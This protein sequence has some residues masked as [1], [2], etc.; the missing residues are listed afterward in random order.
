MSLNEKRVLQHIRN[1]ERAL[2]AYTYREP[3]ARFLTQYYKQNRQ[4]GS[5][6]RKM[7]S[8]LCYNY[9][10]IGDWMKEAPLLER[11]TYAEYLCEHDS[12]IVQLLQPQLYETIQQDVSQKISHVQAVIEDFFPFT[13]EFSSGIDD[14]EFLQSQLIQPDLF[15]RLRRG[16]EERILSELRSKDIKFRQITERT[17]AL[18]NGTNL[19]QLD[20]L[21]GL[22]EIQDLSSQRTL[23]DIEVQQG[24][25]WW[26]ACAASGGKALLLLD[27]YPH[28]NLLVSD[29]RLSILRNLDERFE[30]ARIK[31]PY[32]KKIID[33]TQKT[34]ILQ[35]ET[36]DGI[37]LDAPCS[38]SG[39]WGRTPEMKVQF[40]KEKLQA[41]SE[42]QRS[43][44]SNVVSSLKPG[45]TLTYITCSVYRAENEAIVDHLVTN[46]KMIL[47]K[48]HILP[49]YQE[50]ADT[51]FVAQL[52]KP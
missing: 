29:V 43:L 10:R 6:D 15:I 41:F 1:F 33:L 38:G 13:A 27:K 47:N 50:K 14:K 34:H 3:L 12:P 49:G 8:R 26:D 24:E 45:K 11:L 23:D 42:L 37:I 28:V 30:R 9:F 4:M 7:T 31:T 19:L 16:S 32:R 5:S 17:L 40:S 21:A 2:D 35:G 39:T 25:K 18:P 52:T 36:F 22:Y 20:R 44:S 51:M 48:M 46:H